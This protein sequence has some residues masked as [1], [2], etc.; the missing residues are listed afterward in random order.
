MIWD[1]AVKRC[2]SCIGNGRRQSLKQ[3]RKRFF[4]WLLIVAVIAPA[5]FAE[6][7]QDADEL[8]SKSFQQAHLW[9][10][11]PVKLVA[12]VRVYTLGGETRDLEYTVFWAGPEKW[13][14]EWSAPDMQQITVLNDGKLAYTTNM[15]ELR[16]PTIEFESALAALDGGA[17]AGPYS[18]APLAYQNQK[19]H[20]SEGK[21]N[22]IEA[23]CLA[24]GKPKTT[25]CIDPASGHLLTADGDLS[26]FEYGDYERVG[27][28][29][30]PQSVKVSYVTPTTEADDYFFR[31]GLSYPGGLKF[32]QVKTPI[33][34]AHVTVTRGE[35]FPDSLFAA[36]A[37]STTADLPSCADPAGNFTAPRLD[38]SVKAKRPAAAR[39]SSRYGWLWVLA[40][41][42]KD[43]SVQK[44]IVLKGDPE[45]SAGATGAVQKYKYSPYI[46]CG[47]AAGFQQVVMVPFAPPPPPVY[48]DPGPPPAQHP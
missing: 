7:Q 15:P 40:I 20:V 32:S 47:E 11:S 39:K 27:S 22:G 29:S 37:Q 8:L 44:T 25:L 38:K 4:P 1:E 3:F 14:A 45:L 31:H 36:P 30:Y 43:G 26:S 42:S 34:D 18:L 48:S 2:L 6:T 21:V 10:Q 41:V 28:N 24:F 46:R 19:L 16:W 23:R 33:A 5:V 35:Q 12:K 9:S 13:R 17:P